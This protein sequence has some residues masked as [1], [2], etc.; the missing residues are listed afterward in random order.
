MK[1]TKTIFTLHLIISFSPPIENFFLS[2]FFII[3]LN[4]FEIFFPDEIVIKR[5]IYFIILL[6]LTK[7]KCLLRHAEHNGLTILYS[8]TE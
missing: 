1:R 3:V 6:I 8:I 4:L 2:K 7:C 5:A